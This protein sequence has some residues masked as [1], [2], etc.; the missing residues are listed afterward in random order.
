MVNHRNAIVIIGVVAMAVLA[1]LIVPTI[2]ILEHNESNQATRDLEKQGIPLVTVDIDDLLSD[3]DDTAVLG[4]KKC[5]IKMSV[6][7][8][9]ELH[10]DAYRVVKFTEAGRI[11]SFHRLQVK[12]LIEA[13]C[14]PR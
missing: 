3:V 5:S 14:G 1:A 4:T 9:D 11:I 13:K 10:D 12:A 2:A 7:E 6:Y 8:V